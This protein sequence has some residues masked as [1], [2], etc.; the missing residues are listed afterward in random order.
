M[1]SL[2]M[3]TGAVL[4]LSAVAVVGKEPE[5]PKLKVVEVAKE[6]QP[7]LERVKQL[8]GADF[9]IIFLPEN[10]KTLKEAYT[11]ITDKKGAAWKRYVDPVLK[12]ADPVFA[13]EFTVGQRDAKRTVFVFSPSANFKQMVY[14]YS[15]PDKK[16][17]LWKG[18][19]VTVK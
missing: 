19:F 11:L 13:V 8:V 1:R 14:V 10:T 17:W 2:K 16:D 15:S 3:L 12:D 4:F 18:S 5:G 7:Q 6:I 9:P